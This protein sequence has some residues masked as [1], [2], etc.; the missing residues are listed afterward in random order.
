M[1]EGSSHRERCAESKQLIISV[2]DDG[3]GLSSEDFERALSPGTRLD[4]SVPGTGLG[5]GVVRDL[6]TSYG[7]KLVLVQSSE[8]GGLGAS[9]HLPALS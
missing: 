1:G 2:E 4:E 9:L 8:A 3:V 5:L 6:V 7:G